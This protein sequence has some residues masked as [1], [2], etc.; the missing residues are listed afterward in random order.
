[1]LSTRTG[2]NCFGKRKEN[3]LHPHCLRLSIHIDEGEYANPLGS[4][5][6]KNKMTNICFKIG[7]FDPRINSSLDRIYLA[8]M[9][10]S[11]VLK[12][13]GYKKVLQPLIED[14][15]QLESDEGIPI[16]TESGVWIMRAVLVHVLGDTLALHDIY[17]MSGPSAN[18][19][20]RIC[21]IS[22]NNL[23]SGNFGG[24]F[25]IRTVESVQNALISSKDGQQSSV[26]YGIKT[27]CAL[28]L[29]KYFRW[30]N[31]QTL[32][33][34]HDILEGIVPMIIKKI[35]WEA[36]Y[37]SKIITEH[38]VNQLI[39]NFEY[40][41][42]EMRDKPSTNFTKL[43]LKSK[44]N[45]LS[46]S[47]AQCWLLLRSFPF[48]FHEILKH[49]ENHRE[50]IA[51]LL[52]ITYI[53]F[54]HKLSSEMI[55]CLSDSVTKFHKLFRIC[56][57]TTNAINKIHHIIHYAQ[58]C[59]E[60]GPIAHFSCMMFEAKFK[61]SNAQSRTCNNFKNLSLS[62]TKR[63]NLKQINSISKHSY[64]ADRPVIF[65]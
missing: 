29:L 9:V 45:N 48:I 19:F 60:N 38:E 16:K 42:A 53:S 1:M 37:R 63:L 44:T 59:R 6:G 15:S 54:S 52:N 25:Y 24:N 61:K 62:L 4:R 57:P 39:D 34:M 64:F 26:L 58:V 3:K 28:H 14:F 36:V 10:K 22:R 18:M 13:Y 5:K 20:C 17:G 31:S 2:R 41:E 23:I 30:P 47:A 32:D 7:N 11:Y 65:N 27:S 55:T 46:Q 33:P 12:K 56:F 21:E 51:A 49:N 8:L 35:L 50:I 40:G 43:S